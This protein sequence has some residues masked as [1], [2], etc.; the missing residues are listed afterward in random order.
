MIPCDQI[1][2]SDNVALQT[3]KI[4]PCRKVKTFDVGTPRLKVERALS[5]MDG[6]QLMLDRTISPLIQSNQVMTGFRAAVWSPRGAD[7][8]GRCVIA[9]LSCDHRLCIHESRQDG[10][11]WNKLVELSELFYEH[12]KGEGFHLADV[13]ISQANDEHGRLMEEIK[14]RTYCLAAIAVSWSPVFTACSIHEMMDRKK[15]S[16]ADEGS[17]FALLAVAMKSG[18]VVVWKV[19]FPVTPESCHIDHMLDT[20]SEVPTALGWARLSDHTGG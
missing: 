3:S 11:D 14:W 16:L 10:Q 18:H 13:R 1:Y 19:S 2:P 12:V 5:K 15:E 9:S 7:H 6:H 4:A 17:K 8:L 20:G